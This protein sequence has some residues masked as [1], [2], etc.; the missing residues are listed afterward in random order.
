M[1]C[2]ILKTKKRI[3]L[4][5]F[6]LFVQKGFVKKEKQNKTN[7]TLILRLSLLWKKSEIPLIPCIENYILQSILHA[8]AIAW[9]GIEISRYKSITKYTL[10]YSNSKNAIQYCVIRLTVQYMVLLFDSTIYFFQIFCAVC[11]L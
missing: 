1:Y 7:N 9:P 11:W 8:L 3:K 10:E 4:I 6:S 2:W 5:F